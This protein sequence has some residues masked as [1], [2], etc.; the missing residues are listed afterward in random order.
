MDK[1]ENIIE[2]SM[3]EIELFQKSG[4]QKVQFS[5]LGAFDN[6][7]LQMIN[8]Y[9]DFAQ[10]ID[11]QN[12]RT[13]LFKIFVELSQ[14]ISQNSTLTKIVDGVKIGCGKLIIKEYKDYFVMVS[15]NPARK[16][17]AELVLKR[18]E[19]ING[20]NT[21]ELR[22]MKREKIREITDKDQNGNIGLIIIAILS[23]NEVNV[24]TKEINE[25]EVFVSVSTK[26]NK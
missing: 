26:H 8:Q 13:S 20:K 17:D 15:N 14:N 24:T 19:E 25:K 10:S 16:E 3:K 2:H 5:Y 7:N 9:I 22:Q 4:D 11:I 12:R 1:Y 23:G 18:C 6:N 21:E